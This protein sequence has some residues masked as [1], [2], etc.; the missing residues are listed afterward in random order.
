MFDTEKEVKSVEYVS[1]PPVVI[2]LKGVNR[3]AGIWD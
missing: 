3:D 2:L 1:E